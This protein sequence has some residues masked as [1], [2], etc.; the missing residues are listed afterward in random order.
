[1][2]AFFRSY[3]T[4][5]WIWIGIAVVVW[6]GL[7]DLLLNRA[8]KDYLFRAALHDAGRGPFVSLSEMMHVAVRDAALIST[9][10]A[11]VI[12]LAGLSTAGV[13]SCFLRA[14]LSGRRRARN[15]I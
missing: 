14:V 11:A 13:R 7:Y 6:N 5:I 2:A 10:W 8:A 15:K 1:M 9:L 12:L 3:R 4:A